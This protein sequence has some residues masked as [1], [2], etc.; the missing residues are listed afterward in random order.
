MDLFLVAV[1][2]RVK[3]YEP[4]KARARPCTPTQTELSITPTDI[5]SQQTLKAS[6]KS[7]MSN[8]NSHHT[9]SQGPRVAARPTTA[10]AEQDQ[11]EHQI[12]TYPAVFLVL[13]VINT[14]LN[15]LITQPPSQLAQFVTPRDS[16]STWPT[17]LDNI[18]SN[19][20][21][22][23][24]NGT[25]LIFNGSGLLQGTITPVSDSYPIDQANTLGTAW[26]AITIVFTGLWVITFFAT[27]VCHI[28]RYNPV[29]SIVGITTSLLTLC[30]YFVRD[31][32]S[33]EPELGMSLTS[34]VWS[35][36]K[37]GWLLMADV[38]IA[39]LIREGLEGVRDYL[40]CMGVVIIWMVIEIKEGIVTTAVDIRRL[41]TGFD[42]HTGDRQQRKR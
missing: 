35:F 8:D 12:E 37:Q 27:M 13:L 10:S 42:A 25:T 31:S 22:T 18:I 21:I 30:Y 3:P 7:A 39:V 33:Q 19:A 34:W 23:F 4:W 26:F 32:Q 15:I 38:M 40:K 14:I 28:A 2:Q 1:A 16:I 41:V 17:K 9:A 36:V 5:K 20:T 11:K 6:Q 24:K 29:F